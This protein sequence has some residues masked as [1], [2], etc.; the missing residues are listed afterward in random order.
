M[1]PGLPQHLRRVKP[2][3]GL[4]KWDWGILQLQFPASPSTVAGL[5]FGTVGFLIPGLPNGTILI[6]KSKTVA[7]P[8]H[9]RGKDME[10]RSWL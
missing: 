7:V 10:A 6:K 4:G 5:G 9:M 2:K 1:P 8:N 3:A